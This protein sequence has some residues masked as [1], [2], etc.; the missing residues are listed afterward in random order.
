MGYT[1][2]WETKKQISK[3][4]WKKISSLVERLAMNDGG[5]VLC[6]EYDRTDEPVHIDGDMIAFNGK[7]PHG[8]ETFWLERKEGWAF[9]KTARKPYDEFV[10]AVLCITWWHAGDC[11]DVSSDGWDDDWRRGLELAQSV[12]PTVEI[13]TGVE[14]WPDKKAGT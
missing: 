5:Q 11:I 6:R 3:A 8:H 13:P 4:K 2:Y 10:T 9:C 1:H 14:S 12:D 7:G